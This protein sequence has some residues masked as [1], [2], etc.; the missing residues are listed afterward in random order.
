MLVRDLALLIAEP[1]GEGT[2]KLIIEEDG[3]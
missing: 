2:G 1:G 3:K